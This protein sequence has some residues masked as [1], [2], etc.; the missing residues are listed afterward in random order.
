VNTLY[1]GDNLPILRDYIDS[2]SIDLVYLDPPFKSNQDYNVLFTEQDG[3]R[4]AAQ[5]LAFEDTW[6]W[7]EISSA[8][9]QE[10]VEAGGRVS[11][12]M[13]SFM[14]FLG[15][16]DV[17]AYLAM[18]APR[19]VELRRVLKSTGSIYLHCD[20]TASAYLRLLM[21]AIFL[22]KN[23]RNEIVWYYY[24]KMHDSRK[25]LFPRATDTILFY[26]KDV[27]ANFTYQQLKEMRPKPIKQLLRKKVEGRM[28]NVKDA[29]GH[30][31]YQLK[32]DRTIDNVWRIPML[33]P[34][35]QERL[36]YPTQKPEAL[37]DRVILSSTNEGDLVLD[38]FCGCGTT[39]ASAERLGRE[40]I[41]IDITHVAIGLIKHRLE[42]TYGGEVQYNVIG[43]PVALEDAEQ[44]ARDDPY[45]F[46]WWA[47]G[48]LGARL[49]ENKKGADQG[50]D[51]R[52]YFHDDSKPGT[53]KQVVLSVKAG[54][55]PPAH[56]RELR[57]TVG[58]EDAEIGVL[59]TM[60]E[61]TKPMIREAASAGF[62]KSP[63]GTSHP[64]IQI[65]TVEEMLQGRRIDYPRA[66]NVTFRRAKRHRKEPK[67][68][69]VRLPHTD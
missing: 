4:A 10:T 13:Q 2:E 17:M 26:V 69:P 29:E 65:I 68:A 58:R 35:A 5:M 3:T 59:L 50:I 54:R 61:P 48:T 23:F 67:E 30:V 15:G 14:T 27:D 11:Q 55:I 42:H 24:N 66:V 19:L 31:T 47:A 37:L 25:K 62:Y 28:V 1:Y 43:E 39:I 56:I 51:G 57:G 6:E 18:M 63:L 34:A 64:R 36:G 16:N 21:D 53:T 20:V 40:W 33:Q 41:G 44:L 8:A 46:Q 22:P 32:E 7:N 9:Y 49:T 52:L 60:Q 12:V 45:Q 38:P